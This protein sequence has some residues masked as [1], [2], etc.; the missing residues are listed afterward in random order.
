VRVGTRPSWLCQGSA[1]LAGPGVVSPSMIGDVVQW[2]SRT[3]ASRCAYYAL[4]TNR[5]PSVGVLIAQQRQ[6]TTRR[7]RRGTGP[8]AV[9]VIAWAMVAD[10]AL[11]SAL[12][13]GVTL[14]AGTARLRNRRRVLGTLTC[15]F[16]IAIIGVSTELAMW[17][18]L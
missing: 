9:H 1:Q 17:L 8:A 15:L 3:S 12:E 7:Q 10:P 2:S 4:L 6:P 11:Q 5:L 13:Y 18:V 14:R 16:A